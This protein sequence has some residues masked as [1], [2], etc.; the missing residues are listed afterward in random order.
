MKKILFAICALMGFGLNMSAQG[1][2]RP[3]NLSVA[4]LGV[5]MDG[6]Q[7]LRVA[8]QGR[9]RSD[10]REHERR[11]CRLQRASAGH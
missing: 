8:G 6:S 2:A 5:E 9:N 1:S 7:T 11:R 3:I 10:A 4:W